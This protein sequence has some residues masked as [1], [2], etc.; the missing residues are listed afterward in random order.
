MGAGR[1]RAQSHA[2]SECFVLAERFQENHLWMPVRFIA[3]V[4]SIN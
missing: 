2:Q 1:E 4:R 3:G